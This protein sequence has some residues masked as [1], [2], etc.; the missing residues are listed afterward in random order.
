MKSTLSKRTKDEIKI[1]RQRHEA[2][3]LQNHGTKF[4]FQSQQ[5]KDKRK[6]SFIERYGVDHY[7][8]SAIFKTFMTESQ[9]SYTAD[10]W[11]K[12]VSKRK[13]T[14]VERYSVDNV[15]KLPEVHSKK[16]RSA[17]TSKEYILQSGKI[18][19]VQ[20]YEHKA[21]DILLKDYDESEIMYDTSTIP[22]I[23]YSHNGKAR[24]Y[25]PDFYIPK[26]NLI[27]EVKSQWTYNGK[28]EWLESNLLKQQACLNAGYNFQFMVL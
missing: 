8:K 11:D 27:I 22:V 26:D 1:I 3:C 19:T 6:Q 21:L 13:S 9:S 20:G 2:T 10:D 18:I 7:S 4:T 28:P 17:F 23:K 24:H 15:A 5:I 16:M 25:F 12:I 14:C